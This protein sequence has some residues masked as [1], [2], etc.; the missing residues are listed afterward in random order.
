M[1]EAGW[2]LALDMGLLTYARRAYAVSESPRALIQRLSYDFSPRLS[3]A[4]PAALEAS[5][6]TV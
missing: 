3:F 1:G 5:S 4:S 6:A 2:Q